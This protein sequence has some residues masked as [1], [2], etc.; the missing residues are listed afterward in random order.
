MNN[1]DKKFSNNFLK[2]S[3]IGFQMLATIG[4]LT[5]IG[6][7]VDEHQASQKPIYTAIMGI[8]GVAISLY[9]VIRQLNK[10]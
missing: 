3:S 7:K 8:L 1:E 9:Q 2:Y 10:K 6:Y 4:V 5:F